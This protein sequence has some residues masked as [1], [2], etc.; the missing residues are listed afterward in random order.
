[1]IVGQLHSLAVRQLISD[2]SG[3]RKT[4]AGI[5][6]HVGLS[7]IV[8]EFPKSSTLIGHEPPRRGYPP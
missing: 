1:M 8:S 6:P 3:F 4:A 7:L 5:G 2:K